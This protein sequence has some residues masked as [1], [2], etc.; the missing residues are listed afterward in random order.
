M[1][2]YTLL[3][4]TISL[5]ASTLSAKQVE[6]STA[7]AIAQ[8]YLTK[9][10][11]KHMLGVNHSAA[12]KLKMAIEAKSQQ[13]ATDYYVFNNEGN[14]GYII[15]AGDDR[16]VPVLGYSDEGSFDPANMPDGL[17]YMLELYAQEM[18]YLRSNPN[19]MAADQSL[20]H[21][22]AVKPLLKSN[23]DQ[24]EPY[25]RLCPDYYVNDQ[26]AGR[27]ATGCVATAAAQVM[28]YHR[29]PDA[30][31]GSNTYQSNEMTIDRDFN[32]PYEWDLMLDNYLPGKYTEE[33]G[34]AVATLLYDAGVASE[35]QYGK[36]SSTSAHRMMNAL[37]TNFKFNKGMFFIMRNT[38]TLNEWEELIFNELNNQRPIIYSGFTKRG[39]HTFVLDG[40][41]E[42]GYFHFNWGW[43]SHSNGYFL[44]TALNPRDQGAGSYEGGYNSAQSIII[45]AYPDKGDPAPGT[46]LEITLDSFYPYES[47]VTLGETIKMEHFGMMGAGY[48]CDE[49]NRVNITSAF[50]ITDVND[51]IVEVVASTERDL[52]MSLG[53]RYTAS[54]ERNTAINFTPST[55]LA[56]GDYRLHF[57]YKCPDAGIN[58]YKLYDHSPA[59]KGY[60]NVHVENGV[61]TFSKPATGSALAVE[62][63]NY[64]A[65]VGDNTFFKGEIIFTNT[66]NDFQG[67]ITI[68]AKKTEETEYNNDMFSAQIDVPNGGRVLVKCD[69]FA[70]RGAGNYQMV[71]RDINNNI[72]DGPRN[73]VVTPNEGY[74]L[75]A[76]TQATVGNYYMAPDNITG[77]IDVKNTGTGEYVGPIYYRII[78]GNA[79]RYDGMTEVM[80]IP[81]GET[82]TVNI[83]TV[84]EGLPDTE[85]KL[86]F[87]N[88]KGDEQLRE[89]P[90]MLDLDATSIDA[91]NINGNN[92]AV[93]YVNPMGQVSNTPFKG[94]NIVIDGDKTYKVIK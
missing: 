37:R 73:I 33:Q 2:R 64:P 10:S 54:V 4:L 27:S 7:M 65:E 88:L 24:G 34:D 12:P 75:T 58:E 81:A 50:V 47:Q 8:S 39:G 41:N 89:V 32:H 55:N 17:R 14:N 48:G 30:G 87:F 26:P 77:T 92:T 82:R 71:I 11:P 66:G 74:E 25:N 79:T 46:Y 78:E 63:F 31:V 15:I 42:D 61:M 52:L 67:P 83:K 62:S 43:S 68:A 28:Y 29:W 51:N 36:S 60:L 53:S 76:M 20:A 45:N 93:R 19:A 86:Y 49:N 35:M 18:N 6:R 69:L 85:Y 13:G 38:K 1:K 80:K 22:P 57:M 72:I 23:W 84:F 5:L 9:N 94:L 16:A 70:P 44:I 90:F 3:F 56:D 21:N 40:Y 59:I 91:I